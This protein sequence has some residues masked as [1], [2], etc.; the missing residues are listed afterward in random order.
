MLACAA[1]CGASDANGEAG[2]NGLALD[3]EDSGEVTVADAEVAV[4]DG[5]EVARAS[6]VTDSLDCAVEH[7]ID[8]G[9]V[10]GEVDAVV[11]RAL[12][13]EWVGAIA[14]R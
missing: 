6:V 12:A 1:T 7:G 2:E 13:G 5:D 11:H 9:V 3:S 10:G 8:K 4:A 14:E